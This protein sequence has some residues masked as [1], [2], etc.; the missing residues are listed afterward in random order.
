MNN[1]GIYIHF[2]FCKQKCRYCDFVSYAGRLDEAERYVHALIEEMKEYAGL[3]VDSVYLGGGTPT[4]LAPAL[5]EQVLSA[6]QRFFSLT[7][8]CEITLEANPGTCDREAFARLADAGVNRVSLG[9]QS[10]V[11]SE[12]AQ[13]GRIHSAETAIRAAGAVRAAGIENLS[14]DL[15]FSIPHQTEE[16]LYF[17][18]QQAVSLEPEHLSCYSLMLCEGTPLYNAAA[19]GELTLPDEDEDR[20]RYALLTEFLKHSGYERYEISN[21]AKAGYEAKHNTKYWTREP[22]IGLGAAAHSFFENRRFEN[23]SD[24]SGYYNRVAAGR[25]PKGTAVTATDAMAEF[26][27]L[28]LRLTKLGVSRQAFEMAFAKDLE[29]VYGAPLKKLC[30]LGLLEDNGECFRLTDRGIDVSNAVFCEFL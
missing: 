11:D 4:A 29:D 16:S 21:F 23:P 5:L 30:R 24:F 9:V 27:F 8:N 6:L 3:S 22:Y 10:F 17:S 13:L 20:R 28:S 1:T 7:K 19:R 26:M 25:H 14:L 18:L 2:P 12:L 15:M